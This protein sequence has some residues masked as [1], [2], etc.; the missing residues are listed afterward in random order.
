LEHV[1]GM[2]LMITGVLSEPMPSVRAAAPDIPDELAEIIDHS[3][4]KRKDERIDS[5]RQL[6]DRLQS[7]LE[8]IK[9]GRI[10]RKLH[11]DQSPYPGLSVF[12]ESDTHRFFGRN[13]DIAAA[14]ARLRDQPMLGV[15]G[16]SGVGKS[17]F[18][19]AG[20]VPALKESGTRWALKVIRPGREPL[21]AMGH[22][23]A[24][25][26]IESADALTSTTVAA[27]VSQL[28][29]LIARLAREPGY[30]GTVLR[31]WA[32]KLDG[33]VL[34]FVDQCEELYTLCNDRNER[35]AFT[36]CLAS[37][38]DDATSPLRVVVSIRS[39]FLDRV[40]E[41]QHFMAELS[42]G[43][44]FLAPP[45]R[46]GLR[47]ALVQ[48]AE[49]A[50]HQFES[51]A[52][53]EN[54]LDHLEHIPGALPLLQFAASTLWR[55][56]DRQCALLTEASYRALGGIA[57]ALAG[58]AD[59]CLRQFPSTDQPL[60]RAIFL[61]LVTPER[62]RA[63]VSMGELHALG[64]G[65][66]HSS[67]AV[68]RIVDQLVCARLLVIQTQAQ[69]HTG[70]AA[71]ESSQQPA[72]TTVEIVHESL[73][74]TW[75]TLRRW[76]DETQ[77]DA[78][79]LEQ[80]RQAA[81]NW[82]AKNFAT[83]LVWRGEAMEEARRFARR[84]R[85]E[86]PQLQRAYLDAVFALAARASRRKRRALVAIISTLS[87]MVAAA[88]VALVLIRDAQR[89]AARQAAAAHA[90]E[91]QVRAQLAATQA[92]RRAEERALQEAKDASRHK[93]RTY[94]EL[95]VKQR[96]LEDTVQL[97]IQAQE[98]ALR[99]KMRAVQNARAAQAANQSLQIALQRESERRQR[100]ESQLRWRWIDRALPLRGQPASLGHTDSPAV[101]PP[102][103]FPRDDVAEGNVEDEQ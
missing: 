17:S 81:K 35:R 14:V 64:H 51:T 93:Q 2:G 6:G 52:M 30:L 47:D 82:Q 90:A 20:V 55:D 29:A 49:M 98:T 56:R 74:H 94:E 85:G 37:A 39:D 11:A 42:R 76:L 88:A 91:Q 61:R 65:P 66:Q 57:G 5:A 83:D 13:R 50:G 1:S 63:M 67:G 59:A 27:D 100:L 97:A 18:V 86:L 60:I 95:L 19:R 36:A 73:L 103:L 7:A 58:H 38:A 25:M 3:L 15:V 45:N 54:I 10:S 23:M 70:N 77:E 26:L 43:L 48:P 69:I 89:Q 8:V 41:D 34:L 62:T 4:I 78:A 24:P 9:P 96:Q 84:C 101:A 33:Q 44:Y 21:A 31:S 68:Q 92:A 12:Q 71:T 28:Y 80:L 99:A 87:L 16:P 79:F 102:A 32:R 46:D 40:P 53:V 22:M 72:G 75:P